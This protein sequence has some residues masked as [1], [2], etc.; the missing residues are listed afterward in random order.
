MLDVPRSA[1]AAVAA[2]APVRRGTLELVETRIQQTPAAAP[3]LAA[4]EAQ[5]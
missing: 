2:G 3:Y 5:P 1:L 4:A